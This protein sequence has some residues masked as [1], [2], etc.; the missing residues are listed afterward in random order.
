MP[1]VS[2]SFGDCWAWATHWAQHWYLDEEGN[3]RLRVGAL[4]AGWATH[5]DAFG[6]L[7]EVAFRAAAHQPSTTSAGLLGRLKRR[8]LD[9]PIRSWGLR[10]ASL[11]R[12]TA[13]LVHGAPL[14][15]TEIPTPSMVEP[16]MAVARALPPDARNI[17]VTDPRLLKGWRR[18]GFQPT[19]LVADLG[20]QRRALR[21]GRAMTARFGSSVLGELPVME[22]DSTDLAPDAS[23]ALRTMLHHSLPWLL[24]E[25]SAVD[26]L[27]DRIAPRGVAVASDQHRIGRLV[28]QA[29]VRRG[30]PVTVLQH[31]LPQARIGFLPVVAESVATWS[32]ASVDWFARHGTDPSRLVVT[33]NPRFDSLSHTARDSARLAL[34]RT[35]GAVAPPRLLLALSPAAVEN[36]RGLLE[37]V[38]GALRLLPHGTLVVKLHP[39]YRDW[40]FVAEAVGQHADIRDRV[41]VLHR[42]PLTPLLLWADVTL[43]H[44]STVAIESLAAGTPVL[45]VTTDEIGQPPPDILPGARLPIA[46]VPAGVAEASRHLASEL[47]RREQFEGDSRWISHLVGPL[48]GRASQRIADL[49]S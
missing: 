35:L 27:L 14:L 20:A 4:D 9:R 8:G 19:G 48:D 2:A 21:S 33:G 40:Q 29:A 47:G 49:L 15:V 12:L 30:I 38:L 28:H 46:S 25:A 36:N 42:E 6:V 22:L 43:I 32:Q 3:D 17:A 11:G 10:L 34:D 13:P 26:R 41:H 1:L 45:L 5:V 39:G 23:S 44:Q 18:A 37:C 31:G 7:L 24:A 16:S